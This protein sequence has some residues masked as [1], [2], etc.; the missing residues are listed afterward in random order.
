MSVRVEIPP[1]LQHLTEDVTKTNVNGNTVGDCLADLVRQF[2][3]LKEALLDKDGKLHIYIE[4]F[5][6]EKTTYPKELAESVEDGDEIHIV[7]ILS[8]G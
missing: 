2:P 5:V 3:R 6:N 1:F 7:N 8:G 4:I